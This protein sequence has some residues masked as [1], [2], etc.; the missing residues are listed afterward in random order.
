MEVR[1]IVV[2]STVDQKRYDIQTDATTL[3]ELKAALDAAGVGY[4]GLAFYEGLS[5]TEL[6][7]NSTEL[8]H[9]VMFRGVPTNDLVIQL[10]VPNNKIKSGASRSELY[11]YIRA[12]HLEAAVRENFGRSF[13]NVAT[14]DLQSF[15]DSRHS[16]PIADALLFLVD[17]LE[18]NCCISEEDAENV[19]DIIGVDYDASEEPHH[20]TRRTY[21][22][23][24]VSDILG[25]LG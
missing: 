3:G 22:D 11:E 12:N 5:R 1:N 18:R 15:V 23:E 10:T 21:S 2:V 20:N 19:Y 24:E 13:T 17:T 16:C 6:L 7:D 9:D 4:N 25:F 14:A 8:P